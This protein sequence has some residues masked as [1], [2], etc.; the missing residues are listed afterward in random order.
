MYTCNKKSKGIKISVDSDLMKSGR[1]GS[2]VPEFGATRPGN[3]EV[4][5]MFLH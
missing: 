3:P 5:R 2:E 1:L 4:N